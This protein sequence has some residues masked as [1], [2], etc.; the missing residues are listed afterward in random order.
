MDVGAIFI[1][2]RRPRTL[3]LQIVPI[4]IAPLP[5]MLIYGMW[6]VGETMLKWARQVHIYIRQLIFLT[7]PMRRGDFCFLF[8]IVTSKT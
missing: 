3:R 6:I 8:T 7:L 4:Q 1:T 2:E 5:N